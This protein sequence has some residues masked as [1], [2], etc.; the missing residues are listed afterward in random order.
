MRNIAAAGVILLVS[1]GLA[2]ADEFI[3]T[4]TKVEGT[5]LYMTKGGAGSRRAKNPRHRKN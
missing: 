3:A 5:K 2:N 4:I 1:F